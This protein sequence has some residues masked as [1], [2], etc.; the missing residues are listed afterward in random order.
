[1]PYVSQKVL[2][3]IMHN[4]RVCTELISRCS[5]F[6]SFCDIVLQVNGSI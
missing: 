3:F 5:D 4:V 1:M 6:F 2:K